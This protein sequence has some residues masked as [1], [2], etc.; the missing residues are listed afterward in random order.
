MELKEF[1]DELLT[2]YDEHIIENIF[3]FIE[4]DRDLMKKYQKVIADKG[5]LQDV[6]A[7]IG[8]EIGRHYNLKGYSKN[9]EPKSVLVSSVSRLK[10]QF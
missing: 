7:Q 6:N 5:N 8:R 1:T 10:K 4:N 9:H 3:C 2:K